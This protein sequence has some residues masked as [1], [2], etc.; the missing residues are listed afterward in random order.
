[1]KETNSCV[2]SYVFCLSLNLEDKLL[3]LKM[4]RNRSIRRCQQANT[5]VKRTGK[6]ADYKFA[7]L[8]YYVFLAPHSQREGLFLCVK[9]LCLQFERGKKS[10]SM[11]SYYLWEY[12]SFF[13]VLYFLVIISQF[14]IPIQCNTL[15]CQS[16]FHTR[17]ILKWIMNWIY[18][19]LNTLCIIA[20]YSP[21]LTLWV[22]EVN[23]LYVIE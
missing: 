3:F 1:M 15:R 13:L 4:D 11:R 19:N 9:L 7:P 20:N 17:Q 10:V 14:Y 8:N 2:A 5:F 6:S 21:G 23:C 12:S 22:D 16:L 18:Y